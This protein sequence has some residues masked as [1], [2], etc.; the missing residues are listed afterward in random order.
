MCC[1]CYAVTPLHR[2]ITN[3]QLLSILRTKRIRLSVYIIMCH[4][5]RAMFLDICCDT[6]V[7]NLMTPS[8]SRNILF[9][10]SPLKKDTIFLR[11][12]LEYIRWQ[13]KRRTWIRPF[14]ILAKNDPT[15]DPKWVLFYEC[16]DTTNT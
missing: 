10:W 4:L 9:A 15:Y 11:K 5:V 1:R 3:R 12:C 2:Y 7:S 6:T 8:Q 13:R 14:Y 16:L